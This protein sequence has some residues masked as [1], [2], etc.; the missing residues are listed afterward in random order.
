MTEW[1][2][3]DLS[4]LTQVSVQTLHHYDR[5]GLLK[6]SARLENNYRLYSE[7]DLLKLQQIIALKFFGFEL[8]QIKKLLSADVGMLDHFSAQS[9][10]LEEKSKALHEASR[11][12]KNIISECSRDKSIPWE[13]IIKSIEVYRMTQQLEKSWE[14]Q[15]FNPDELKKY[16]HFEQ[17]LKSK[18]TE[19]EIKSFEQDWMDLVRVVDTNLDQDPASQFGIDLGKR[20]M[21]WV[22]AFYGKK[23]VAIRNA[24]WER[25][26]KKG[27]ISEDTALSLESFSWLDK[28]I[29]AYYQ[30][31][32]HHVLS[33]IETQPHAVIIKQ[34]E[35]LLIDMHG[36]EAAPK[37][38][39]INRLLNDNKI[40][41]ATKQWLKKNMRGHSHGK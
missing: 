34:W 13:T 27:Q 22:N 25:G 40:S 28:A 38:E 7:K 10:V 9:Q 8:S 30:N 33:Q 14:G 5:V 24:I 35:E 41:L 17:E 4:K 21:D 20:C 16:V 37:N 11:A 23:H 39:I 31:R 12:L 1:Y 18:Y 3:K 6:P 32:I 26:F 15:V 36:D 19:E 2:V 29:T